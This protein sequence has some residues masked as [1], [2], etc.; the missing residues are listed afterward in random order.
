MGSALSWPQVS[1]DKERRWATAQ[2]VSMTVQ[3]VK[4]RRALWHGRMSREQAESVLR[5]IF[6]EP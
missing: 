4:A 3:D 5:D 1:D 6:H 2:L